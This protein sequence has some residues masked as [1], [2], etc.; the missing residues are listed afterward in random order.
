[1]VA[2]LILF[3][4]TRPVSQGYMSGPYPLR[5]NETDENHSNTQLQHIPK[6]FLPNKG[7][8]KVQ[9]KVRI[10]SYETRPKK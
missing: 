6:T 3:L 4:F 1:M 9:G 7:I 8:W 5:A 2:H 10:K